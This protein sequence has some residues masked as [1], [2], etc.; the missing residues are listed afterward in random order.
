MGLPGSAE[1]EQRLR[2]E[3]EEEEEER[4]SGPRVAA[5][6]GRAERRRCGALSE[7][8]GNRRQRAGAGAERA[9]GPGG[10]GPGAGTR[11][12]RRPQRGTGE[13]SPARGGRGSSRAAPREQKAPA[14]ESGAAVEPFPEQDA[15]S[16]AP[17]R[18]GGSADPVRPERGAAPRQAVSTGAGGEDLG[19]PGRG[20]GV[21]AGGGETG[22]GAPG[23]GCGRNKAS[24]RR[25]APCQHVCTR[26]CKSSKEKEGGKVILSAT[27]VQLLRREA[28]MLLSGSSYFR[29]PGRAEGSAAGGWGALRCGT[30]DGRAFLCG[31]S[32]VFF[33]AFS[34]GIPALL[35]LVWVRFDEGL[36]CSLSRVRCG[37]S[38]S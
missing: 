33:L 31:E 36:L 6:L 32:C 9:P 29:N 10:G 27:C 38:A 24:G 7:R 37:S 34:S 21:S 23:G 11:R 25:G 19:G 22:R 14:A 18:L 3:G 13:P 5:H 2:W 35:Q 15:P 8:A 16:G 26:R 28:A 4:P 1:G 20:R 17:L 30:S 12:G